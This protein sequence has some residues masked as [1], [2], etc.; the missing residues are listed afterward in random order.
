MFKRLRTG[1]VE[2]NLPTTL[3]SPNWKTEGKQKKIDGI[4]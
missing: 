2:P 1:G 4:N 3:N